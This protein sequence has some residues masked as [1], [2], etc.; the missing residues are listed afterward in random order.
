M[1]KQL[2]LKI[3]HCCDCPNKK[4][5]FQKG[6]RPHVYCKATK[7]EIK[8]DYDKSGAYKFDVAIPDWCPLE[9][10]KEQS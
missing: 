8:W 9:D 1:T 10:S 4:D 6:R 5:I 7:N 2:F 3:N